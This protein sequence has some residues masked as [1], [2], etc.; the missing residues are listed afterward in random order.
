[1]AVNEAVRA[2]DDRA[3]EIADLLAGAVD[4]HCHSGPAA[5]PRMLDHHEAMMDAAAA[6]FSALLYKDHFYAGMA[7][8]IL[9]EKLFP[10]T[11]VRLYSGVALNN[12]SGG[13]NPHAVDHT[14]KLGGKI[15]W[16]PTFAA[17]NHIEKSATETKN[18][19]K[20]ANPM[21]PPIPLSVLGDNGKLTRE[22]NE[23]LDVIAAGDIILAGG[24]LAVH[25][26]KIMFGEAKRRGVRK[27]LVNHPTYVIGC[28]DEDMLDLTRMGVFLEHSIC[29][30]IECKGRKHTP[31]EVA[32]LIRLVGADNTIL[33]SDLG[34][35]GMPRPVDGYREIVRIL[36][37]LQFSRAEIRK[38]VGGNA[39]TLL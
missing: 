4:L 8:A 34:L 11:G 5:F 19:P 25:E 15:V 14:V 35:V 31:D 6:K 28:N 33:G 30:L 21:L 16:M 38:L 37:D 13:I 3:A 20:S 12:A 23:V 22:T 1:M 36:L 39:K 10:D 2:G 17:A 7:H 24:H 27:M 29:M 32:H 9:L 18:Y 26:Q